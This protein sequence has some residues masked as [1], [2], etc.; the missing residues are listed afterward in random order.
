[1]KRAPILLVIPTLLFTAACRGDAIERDLYRP[2]MTQL[3]LGDVVVDDPPVLPEARFIPGIVINGEDYDLRGG[4]MAPD[5]WR[6]KTDLSAMEDLEDPLPLA[7]HQ[8][9][10]ETYVYENGIGD[11]FDLEEGGIEYTD[12]E[13]GAIGDCYLVAALSAVLYVDEDRYVRDGVIREVKDGSGAVTKFVVR[14][15]D[16]WGDPQDIEVDAELMRKGGKVLYARSMDT[17]SAGEEWAISLIEKAYAQWHTD[18]EKIG[19]GGYAGDVMQALTGANATY[20]SVKYLSD[21]SL[22]DGINESIEKNKPVVAGTFGEDDDVDYSG[23]GVYAWHAYSVLGTKEGTEESGPTVTLRNPWGSVEP[24]GNGEDDGIFDLTVPDFRRLY[25][26]ITFGGA[27]S[28]DYTAPSAVSDLALDATVEGKVTLRWTATGDDGKEGLAAA[29]DMRMSTSPITDDTFYEADRVTIADPQSPGTEETAELDDIV[30][31]T[32]YYVALK[33]EDESGNISSMSNVLDFAIEAE[34][35]EVKVG[36]QYFDFESDTDDWTAKGLFHLTDAVAASPIHSFA[37]HDPD[38]LDYSTGD[39]VTCDLI[40]PII[41]LDG[42]DNPAILWE[43]ILDVEEGEGV[44]QAVLEIATESGGYEDFKPVWSKEGV[45]DD[46][47]LGWAELD[48]YEGQRVMFRFSFDSIDE[49]NNTG[50]G[51]IIDDVWIF[52]N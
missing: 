52:A 50:L 4:R 40:S 24:A 18:Y 7:K 34:D 27:S 1:M 6:F 46:F 12:V 36:E 44:D 17:S 49:N 5:A 25:S 35:V 10:P 42:L 37:C 47:D 41:D 21:S 26:G 29:Y 14:F 3:R 8:E 20:R 11:L 9:A 13:Q 2:S 19:N 43:Q 38:T 16:A 33:I 28:S 31:G 30:E 32:T 51:W 23:T 22:I 39:R 15:Y 48:A 45:S